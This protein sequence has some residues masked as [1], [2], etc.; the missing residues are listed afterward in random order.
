MTAVTPTRTVPILN[1]TRQYDALQSE[2][3]AAALSV[4]RSGNYV[5]GPEV[6]AFEQAM[7]K[8]CQTQH[9]I[10]VANGTDSLYL[11]LLAF[12]IGP[13]DEVITTCMS[14]IATSEVIERV[15][16]T[17][18][19]VDV[20]NDGTYLMDIDACEQA[21][22]PRTKAIIPVHL[23]GQ[24]VD[25]ERLMAVANR[26][27]LKVI[28]DC[29]QA[30]DATWQG[31]PVGGWGH[32]GSFSFFPSKNLGGFGDGG[33]LT[34]NNTALAQQLRTRRVHGQ[35][36]TYDHAYAGMNSRLDTLQAALLH[37]KLPHLHQWAKQRATH[38]EAYNQAFAHHPWLRLP[39]VAPQATSVY[40]QYTLTL[41]PEAPLTR[42]TLVQTL[43]ARGVGSRVYYP[44]PL[45]L[46]GV[47]QHLGY[48]AGS[49]PIG[50][51][52]AN[53]VFSLPVF[54]EMTE[55]ERAYVI[56]VVLECLQYGQ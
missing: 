30:V 2:L 23:F 45:H 55:A 53:R 17:P 27:G 56:D 19:F 49:F 5:L 26:H 33:L 52:L 4:L 28:E 13:G 7:A 36:A 15:G 37:V 11:A 1:L 46:Q 35:T 12:G 29:A 3:E 10:G 24:A 48:T 38:A 20:V 6:Q 34:C 39:T 40:N 9:A 44:I 50:E 41:Q 16:A 8:R 14:Y 31:K 43:N 32:V 54:P 51:D 25:M 18:I 42:D 47:H 21:I 22:T